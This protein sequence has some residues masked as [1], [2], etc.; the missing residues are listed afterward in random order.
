VCRFEVADVFE[1]LNEMAGKGEKYDCVVLDPPA[2]VKS[3]RH[4][5]QGEAAYERINRL[6]MELLSA[7]GV[8]I[9]CSCSF[10]I[11]RERFHQILSAA[12]R[13]CRR[14]AVVIEWR[15]Q[16]HDHPVLLAMPETSYLK[17]AIMRIA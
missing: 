17:C 6:A 16:A 8:L 13:K 12:A 5:K 11:S 10:H 14:S 9:S 3:K 7:N 1:R 15:G 4:L 2:L